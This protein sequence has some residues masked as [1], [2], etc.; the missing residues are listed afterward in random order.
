MQNTLSDIK[1]SL[2]FKGYDLDIDDK[3]QLS[4]GKTAF[5]EWIEDNCDKALALL[6][7]WGVDVTTA[8]SRKLKR[9]E[10]QLLTA[11]A[12]E[13]LEF[14][15]TV[16]PQSLSSAGESR[17]FKKLSAEDRGKKVAT[18]KDNVYFTL[19]GKYAENSDGI[20]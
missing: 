16:D 18:I 7:N 8:D 3:T 5:E 13:H 6:Q 19:F 14:Q 11:Y 17:S 12:I 4:S 10:I 15:D 2:P 9:A 20:V 1:I